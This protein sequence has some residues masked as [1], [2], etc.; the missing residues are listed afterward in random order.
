LGNGQAV[1]SVEKQ[2]FMEKEF[3]DVVRAGEIL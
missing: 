1:I 2:L 3:F